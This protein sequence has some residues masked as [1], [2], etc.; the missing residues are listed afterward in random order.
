MSQTAQYNIGKKLP[1]VLPKSI[2]IPRVKFPEFEEM[3]MA[4]PSPGRSIVLIAIYAF[5]FWLVAGGIYILIREPISLGAD[6]NGNPLWLYP[7]TSE[8]FII[9]SIVAAAVIFMGGAGFILMYQTTK[10]SFNY[11]Y[12]IKLLIVGFILSAVSFG[13]LQWMINEKGG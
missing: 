6:R 8:A 1:W 2:R 5:L 13:L 10:H 4:L 12:A 3:D 11:N 9:E 7:S